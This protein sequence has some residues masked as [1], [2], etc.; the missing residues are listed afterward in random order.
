MDWLIVLRPRVMAAWS[1]WMMVCCAV[2]KAVRAGF[3]S[4]LGSGSG[5]WDSVGGSVEGGTTG[6]DMVL[7]FGVRW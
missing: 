7:G 4:G 5:A 2:L 1:S 6:F 3:G